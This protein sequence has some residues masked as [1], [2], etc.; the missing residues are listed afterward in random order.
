MTLAKIFDTMI[1]GI[2]YSGGTPKSFQSEYV[3]TEFVNGIAVE[4]NR[5]V[6]WV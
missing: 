1:H 3:P 6:K 4:S 5:N 2:G